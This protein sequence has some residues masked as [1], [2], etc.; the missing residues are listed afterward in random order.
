MQIMIL[1]YDEFCISVGRGTAVDVTSPSQN[2][3]GKYLGDHPAFQ[4]LGKLI[5]KELP[6]VWNQYQENINW[7]ADRTPAAFSVAG[8][9]GTKINRGINP[10]EGKHYFV[11]DWHGSK[12]N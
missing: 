4:V 1:Y 10:I 7:F 2:G 11:R 12:L 9:T 3:Q 5:R 6:T 8:Q